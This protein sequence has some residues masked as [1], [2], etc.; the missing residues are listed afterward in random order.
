MACMSEWAGAQ[1]AGSPWASFKIEVSET[2]FFDIVTTQNDHPSYVKY[3][4]ARIY[5]FFTLFGVWVRGGGGGGAPKG[6]VHTLLKQ[7]STLGS[8]TIKVSETHF[9]K[10]PKLIFLNIMIT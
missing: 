4:L 9:F 6:L 2:Y 10:F 8:S 5:V 1:P 3:V 7:F